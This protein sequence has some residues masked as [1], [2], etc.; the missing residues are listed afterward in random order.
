V[1]NFVADEIA[2]DK[3][4]QKREAMFLNNIG[5]NIEEAKLETMP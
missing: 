1:S 5:V 3:N 2:E 4:Y